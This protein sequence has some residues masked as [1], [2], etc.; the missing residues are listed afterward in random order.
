[1]EHEPLEGAE[2]LTERLIP[3]IPGVYN[4][5]EDDWGSLA[6][7]PEEESEEDILREI[8]LEERKVRKRILETYG[9]EGLNTVSE[10][11]LSRLWE[12][13]GMSD[14]L[15]ADLALKTTLE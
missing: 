13:M 6:E 7:E 1:M 3:D 5:D 10:E 11:N 4:Y 15:V 9:I 8:S 12:R 14:Y 2:D